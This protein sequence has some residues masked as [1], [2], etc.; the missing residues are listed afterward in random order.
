MIIFHEEN[1]LRVKV[2][3]QFGEKI[4]WSEI[5]SR[6]N[7]SYIYVRVSNKKLQVF[8]TWRSH[9]KSLTQY[10]EKDVTYKILVMIHYFYVVSCYSNWGDHLYT[11][12]D[13][14][15][16]NIGFSRELTI[17]DIILRMVG[18]KVQ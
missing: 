12:Y 11:P 4:I 14:V 16:S 15:I 10:I 2:S 8:L 1:G 3:F 5:I 9:T 17:W 7:N 6:A 13:I 18:L